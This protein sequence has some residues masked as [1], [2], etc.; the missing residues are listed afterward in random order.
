MRVLSRKVFTKHSKEQ[1]NSQPVKEKEHLS[2]SLKVNRRAEGGWIQPQRGM[3]QGCPLAPLLFVLA[4]DA[5]VTCMTLACL[6]GMFRGFQTQS[7][8]AVIPLL[9]YADDTTFFIEGSVEEARNLFTLLVLFVNFSGLQI[10]CVKSNLVGFS[11]T[12]EEGLQCLEALRTPIGS[13]P[14]RILGL[15]LKKGKMTRSDWDLVIEKVERRLEGWQ[16]KLLS[17]VSRLVLLQSVLAAILSFS[18][19]CTSCPLE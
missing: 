14:M 18:Y 1:T 10:N 7:S 19:L 2:P 13:L 17:R 8:L 15:P 3:R 11:L 4:M 9:Q 6:Q 16:A 5:L 12:H